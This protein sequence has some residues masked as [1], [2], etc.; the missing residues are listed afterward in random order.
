MR[1]D[2]FDFD[3]PEDLIASEPM[4][5]RDHSRL[6]V[7]ERGR[8]VVDDKHFFDL[9]SLLEAGDLLVLNRTKVIPARFF[10]IGPNDRQFEVMLLKRSS[11]ISTW[12]C[13]VRPGN[14]IP[15]EGLEINVGGD[16]VHLQRNGDTF[17]AALPVF[18]IDQQIAWLDRHGKTPLPPYIKR[19]ATAGDRDRYQTVFAR[20]WGSV[21]APTAGLHFTS[22]LISKLKAQGIRFAELTLHVGYGTFAPVRV[23][24]LDSHDMHPEAYTIPPDTYAAL[25]SAKKEGRR[26]ISVGTTTL[27]ALESIPTLGL[28]GET[29]IFIRPGHQ[30]QWV[31]GLI[32]NFHLPQS[33]LLVLVSAFL[34]KDLTDS[35]YREAIARGY[36]FYSYGDAMLIL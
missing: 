21:A 23:E 36:R 34:G 33:T 1:I 26:I 6:L 14:K 16:P 5:P 31:D 19:E 15:D 9:A 29:K 2:D 18:E 24:D 13:L 27:R 10:G 3:L 11:T 20:E 4:N 22:E 7:V 30:F 32:T 8:G 25:E 12:E 28:A 17:F 35:C